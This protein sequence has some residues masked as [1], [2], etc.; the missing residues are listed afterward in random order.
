MRRKPVIIFVFCAQ[1][2]SILNLRS[3]DTLRAVR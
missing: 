1:E 3:E 2:G